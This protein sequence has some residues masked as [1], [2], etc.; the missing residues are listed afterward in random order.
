MIGIS[1]SSAAGAHFLPP[2]AGATQLTT[3]K[4]R[5]AEILALLDEHEKRRAAQQRQEEE[6]QPML[7]A[8]I[9]VEETALAPFRSLSSLTLDSAAEMDDTLVATTAG[10]SMES[11]D[12]ASAVSDIAAHLP[13]HL[14]FPFATA[15]AAQAVEWMWLLL[16][17]HEG[18]AVA[19][20]SADSSMERL[21]AWLDEA[22]RRCRGAVE[23]RR[24]NNLVALLTALAQHE[25]AQ[26]QF[27]HCGLIHTALTHAT[28]TEH[29]AEEQRARSALSADGSEYEE[30]EDPLYA[31]ASSL[32]ISVGAECRWTQSSDAGDLEL[33]QLLWTLLA[34]LSSHWLC[35]AVIHRGQLLAALLPYVD[36]ASALPERG[37]WPQSTSTGHWLHRRWS[38]SQLL[39][40]QH[41]ALVALLVVA[42][43]MTEQFAALHGVERL[44]CC[45][46][47]VCSDAD[48]ASAIQRQALQALAV[49]AAAAVLEAS[50]SIPPHPELDALIGIQQSSST[51]STPAAS[52]PSSRPTTSSSPAPA[53]SPFAASPS[54]MSTPARLSLQMV[55]RTLLSLVSDPAVPLDCRSD[56]MSALTSLCA[57]SAEHRRVM[58]R[59]HT[60]ELTCAL[61][62]DGKLVATLVAQCP[63]LLT[64]LTSCVWRCIVGDA[65][66]EEAFISCQGVSALL[67]LVCRTSRDAALQ[68]H[69]LGCLADLLH[70]SAAVS[71]QRSAVRASTFTSPAA[72]AILITVS[73]PYAVAVAV[74]W[75]RD[76][77]R[78][79]AE[80][81]EGCVSSV[82]SS[83]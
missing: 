62:N 9:A 56:A 43:T 76:A 48:E 34:T 54:R 40:L 12:F 57:E 75:C 29:S 49:K 60:V 6:K 16:H 25:R 38:A 52:V 24:R 5:E 61:L 45:V 77:E 68:Q 18:D 82:L 66:N 42:P 27:V 63:A 2:I 69:A 51:S 74:L 21:S 71:A 53:S 30:K 1:A 13:S 31:P 78:S 80:R 26:A 22:L 70:S 81:V 55:L 59:E 14:A 58:R 7:S 4:T 33:R 28:H 37:G 23:K 8:L 19:L 64:H 10:R 65:R 3:R 47:A 11:P 79:P 15:E 73:P 17:H 72:E 41:S 44:M 35:H 32:P 46:Q 39:E 20:L 36:C 50:H 83:T 67:D